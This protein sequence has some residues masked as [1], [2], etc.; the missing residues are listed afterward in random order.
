MVNLRQAL[1]PEEQKDKKNQGATALLPVP[2]P[3]YKKVEYAKHIRTDTCN[4]I[5][6]NTCKLGTK[7]VLLDCLMDCQKW[8]ELIHE[9]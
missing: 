5:Q 8:I 7:I 3:V 1:K 2:F 4:A 6:D 9:K